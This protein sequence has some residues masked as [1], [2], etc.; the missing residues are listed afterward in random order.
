M[1]RVRCP[2]F[3]KQWGEYLPDDQR[4]ADNTI[5]DEL[6][7]A[8]QLAHLGGVRFAY[9]VGKHVAGRVLDGATWD[10]LLT[11]VLGTSPGGKPVPSTL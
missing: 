10:Q 9:R 3:F 7:R 4:A 5:A 6:G 8:D 2:V 1:Q 11:L